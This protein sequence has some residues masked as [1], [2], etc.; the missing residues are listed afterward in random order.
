MALP[1][2]LADT[3]EAV[4]VPALLFAHNRISMASMSYTVVGIESSTCG[5]LAT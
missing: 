1:S 5:T 2:P 4:E 3:A